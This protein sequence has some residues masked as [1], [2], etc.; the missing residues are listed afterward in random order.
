M[1]IYTTFTP[2]KLTAEQ[3]QALAQCI[4]AVGRNEFVFALREYLAR[5]P[6]LG[7][8]AVS[9]PEV[10]AIAENNNRS[11]KRVRTTKEMTNQSIIISVGI[12]ICA[13]IGMFSIDIKILR[14][15]CLAIALG[16]P[17]S[18]LYLIAAWQGMETWV[19]NVLQERS[20]RQSGEI[21]PRTSLAPRSTPQRAEAVASPKALAPEPRGTIELRS[22]E[23]S[24]ITLTKSADAS[25]FVHETAH[26]WLEQFRR[27]AAHPRAPTQLRADWETIKHWLGGPA[28]VLNAST[29]EELSVAT[30]QHEYFARG[31]EQ[32]L[33]E[34]N[35]PTRNLSEV[36]TQHKRWL[37]EIYPKESDLNVKLTP[38]IRVVFGRMLGGC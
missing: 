14:L 22:G 33:R 8:K 18:M 16:L 20:E 24:T 29:A 13:F 36:F 11:N 23:R 34:G 1:Y 19:T 5:P 38:E 30:C 7:S 28:D 31:F 6:A 4:Q 21:S 35:A 12:V 32:Y 37:T 15:I 9:L 10:L 3:K 17:A 2:P 26:D 27:D 25:T